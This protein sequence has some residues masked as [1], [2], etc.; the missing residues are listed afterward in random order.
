MICCGRDYIKKQYEAMEKVGENNAVAFPMPAL[1]A[2]DGAASNAALR[3]GCSVQRFHG[4]SWAYQ[5]DKL[6]AASPHQP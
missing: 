1:S 6:Q 2:W 4:V 3:A 5:G